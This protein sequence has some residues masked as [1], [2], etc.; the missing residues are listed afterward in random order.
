VALLRPDG[1]DA[2]TFVVGGFA[3]PPAWSRD[4]SVAWVAPSRV[5]VATPGGP[6]RTLARIRGLGWPEPAPAWSR[7]GRL[8]AVRTVRSRVALV[9]TTRGRVRVLRPPAP[10]DALRG[11]VSWGEQDLVITARKARSDLELVLVRADGS[12]VR[13]LTSNRFADRDPGWSPDGKTIVFARVGARRGLYTIGVGGG[14]VRRLTQGDDRAPA[15]SPDGATI[16]FTRGDSIR[17]LDVRTG[18]TRSLAITRLRPRQL[19]W[20]PDGAAIVFGDEYGVRQV[21]LAT[22]RVATIDVGGLAFRPLVSPDGTRIAFLGYRDERYFRDPAAWGIFVSSID[23]AHVR[24][25]SSTG[26]FGPTSWAPD[27][28]LFAA[29]DGARLQLVDASTGSARLLFASGRTVFG[30]FRPS[31]ARGP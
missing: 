13:P 16:T 25:I 26:K 1:S 9:P 19:S 20:T 4:G 15:F 3:G 11:G 5:Q 31:R 14:P 27:Q 29:T 22:G 23:G 10:A 17:L 2:R 21:D 12:G 24:R 8:L 28:M 30:G 18:L 6:V 7:D